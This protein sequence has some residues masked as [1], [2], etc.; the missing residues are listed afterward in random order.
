MFTVT[1]KELYS[2]PNRLFS[3]RNVIPTV[4]VKMRF[5]TGE[6]F[7]V[8]KGMPQACQNGKQHG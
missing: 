4:K 7:R 1:D 6:M 5:F 2:V 3:F 8:N